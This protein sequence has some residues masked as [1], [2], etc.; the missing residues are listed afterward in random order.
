ML[1]PYYSS[2]SFPLPNFPRPPLTPRST[3][4]SVSLQKRAGLQ[5]TTTKKDKI[6]Y[7]KTRQKPPYQS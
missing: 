1:H 6:V 4:S 3:L 5:D 2:P 7:N